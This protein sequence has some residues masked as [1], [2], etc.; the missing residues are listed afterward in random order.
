MG[1]RGMHVVSLGVTIIDRRRISI[2]SSTNLAESIYAYMVF[3]VIFY[4]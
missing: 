3:V 1:V 2:S 4:N